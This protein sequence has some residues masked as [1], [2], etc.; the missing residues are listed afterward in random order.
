MSALNRLN[1]E[2]SFRSCNE[3]KLTITL[4]DG[5]KWNISP[6]DLSKVICWSPTSRVVVKKNESAIYPY[7]IINL[8]TADSDEI[9]A[10]IS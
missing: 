4:G 10:S 9:L 3:N 2:L 7:K 6:G 5:S 1:E 8:D